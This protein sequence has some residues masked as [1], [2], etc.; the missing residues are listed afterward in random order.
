MA[1]D[2]KHKFLMPR[3]SWETIKRIIRAY[4]AVEDKETPTVEEI[5]KLGDLQ[6]PVVSANN[7]FLR[8]LGIIRPDQNKLAPLGSRIA[9]GLSLGNQTVV[10]EALQDVVRGNET[11]NQLVSTV[12]AR[13]P[14]KMEAFKAQA[15]VFAGLNEKKDL[16][17]F[18]TILDLL[19]ESQ[20]IRI[21]DNEVSFH[22]YYVGEI[23]GVTASRD[24]IQRF[25]RL[26]PAVEP[27]AGGSEGREP[28][29]MPLPL[30]PGRL[31][32]IQLPPD[33]KREELPKLI[34]L[35][36][37]SLGDDLELNKDRG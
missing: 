11:L 24:G 9:S 23:K 14:M 8:S 30:G 17:F 18:R 4:H 36:Q 32:Y 16:A 5:A 19:D 27:S 1:E 29:H 28:V 31:A 15:V 13:G 22:G 6:R 12:R 3:S 25:P 26:A 20:V 37:I 2:K 21:A 35:L 10:M 33:W 7:M 34:K